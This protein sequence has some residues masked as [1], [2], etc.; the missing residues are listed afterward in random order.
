MNILSILIFLPLVAGAIVLLLPDR[1]AQQA[2]PLAM[3]AAAANL[4][5]AI[6]T[7]MQMAPAGGMQLV[8]KLDWVPQWGIAYHVGVDGISI[9]LVLLTTLF[10]LL[11]MIYAL[12]QGPQ[13][14]VGRFYG[15]ILVT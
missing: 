5:L 6:W 13:H 4:A 3:G 11:A 9:F 15:L 14:Q 8:Q 1:L 10:S 12:H 7:W 2:K